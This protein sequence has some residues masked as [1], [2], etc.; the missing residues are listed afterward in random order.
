MNPTS[1]FNINKIATKI[2]IILFWAI[3]LIIFF[4]T[5]NYITGQR[6]FDALTRT[7]NNGFVVL[8]SIRSL[9]LISRSLDPGMF[10][11]LQTTSTRGG[12]L[13]R[14]LSEMQKRWYAIKSLDPN[15]AEYSEFDSLFYRLERT[16]LAFQRSDLDAVTMDALK[17][18]WL[19]ARQELT[20]Y[21]DLLVKNKRDAADRFFQEESRLHTTVNRIIIIGSLAASILFIVLSVWSIYLITRP[22]GQVINMIRDLNEGLFST[23]THLK[24]TDE[25]SQLAEN[26]DA[27]ADTMTSVFKDFID[28]A[29]LLGASSEEISASAVQIEKATD[30]I[31]KGTD[32]E[33]ELL[34]H[35][36]DVLLAI[37]DAINET[38]IEIKDIQRITTTAEQQTEQVSESISRIDQSM[39][40]IQTSGLQI[41]DIVSVITDIANRTNLLSLN[42]AIEAAKAGS[43][44]R[45]F[46]VVAEEIGQLAEK[47][48]ASVVEIKTLIETSI[49]N[50]QDGTRVIQNARLVLQD[51]IQ[52]VQQI[53]LKINDATAKLVDQNA[54]MTDIARSAENVVEISER[55]STSAQELYG[56]IRQITQ[57]ME[58]LKGMADKVNQK[59]SRFQV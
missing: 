39:T 3:A 32:Q 50:I 41:E 5:T 22:L 37:A 53:S 14:S 54:G 7:H 42:A 52:T 2:W 29:G 43:Y 36:K 35:N 46:A 19:G 30:E 55:N 33:A 23:R 40:R 51:I 26:L 4:V 1:L 13:S 38:T 49:T 10:E 8:D 58:L 34:T 20:S 28:N 48:S 25:I 18:E 45:G 12:E 16:A 21:L 6:Y 24:G 31:A 57:T 59:L 9:Q 15:A 47:S 11:S 17:R 44:G 27:F 56:S